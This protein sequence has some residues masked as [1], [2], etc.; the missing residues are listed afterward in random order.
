[1]VSAGGK[2]EILGRRLECEKESQGGSGRVRE[3]LG[4]NHR[5]SGSP[6]FS[7]SEAQ[8]KEDTLLLLLNIG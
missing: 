7:E 2:E 6:L 4:C 8:I 5:Q 1:M 3:S